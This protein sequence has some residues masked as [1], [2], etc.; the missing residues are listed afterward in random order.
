MGDS[1][2]VHMQ[3]V[4]E[5]GEAMTDV[6]EVFGRHVG[7]LRRLEPRNAVVY[8]GRHFPDGY[9]VPTMPDEVVILCCFAAEV[10]LPHRTRI[11]G[12]PKAHIIAELI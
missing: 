11:A 1:A 8:C 9:T 7:E 2:V 3:A 6:L 4:R 12:W 5:E 10:N